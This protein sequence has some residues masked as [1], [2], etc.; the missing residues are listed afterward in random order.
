MFQDVLNKP[1]FTLL[2]RPIE[3]IIS[4]FFL[5]LNGEGCLF[6]HLNLQFFYFGVN[7]FWFLEVEEELLK[8]EFISG[9]G[10]YFMLLGRLLQRKTYFFS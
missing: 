6:H 2:F 1:L 7:V 9:S 10:N 5:L 4:D 8:D 3:S